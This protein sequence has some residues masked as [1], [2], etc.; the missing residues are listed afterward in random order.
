MPNPLG[1]L[2]ET[3]NIRM[4]T[5]LILVAIG[6]VM[7]CANLYVWW[8]WFDAKNWKKSETNKIASDDG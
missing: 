2:S 1:E 3:M 8:E 6:L 4:L 5:C 7:Y